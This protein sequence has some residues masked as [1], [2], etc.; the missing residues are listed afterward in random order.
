MTHI[1]RTTYFFGFR[2]G[3]SKAPNSNLSTK[4]YVG[5]LTLTTTEENL[6]EHFTEF[7]KVE[8]V[9]LAVGYTSKKPLGFAYVT[10]EKKEDAHRAITTSNQ[11]LEGTKITIQRC[12][13]K[14]DKEDQT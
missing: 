11:T 3:R 13:Q 10:F 2:K 1:T 4:L 12:R 9:A 5:N 8:E 7:G 14:A 6:R